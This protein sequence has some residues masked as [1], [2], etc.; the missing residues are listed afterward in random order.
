[1]KGTDGQYTY[2]KTFN[3]ER[4]VI[5][6]D[7]ISPIFFIIVLDQL[8]Q[9]YDKSGKGISVGHIK[10]LRV[11]GYADDAAM[12]EMAV[13]DMTKRLTEFA[14]AAAQE[15]DMTV[16][17]V[18]TYS[19]HLQQQEKV[20][21]ATDEEI[22]TKTA[23]YK[24]VC[25]FA[26]A[27]CKERF[28]TK[29]GMRIHSST[30]NFNYGLT[31]QKWEVEKIIAVFGRAERK[32]FLVRWAN[33][34]GEDS[35][36]KE[37]SLLQDGCAESIK[38]YWNNS[39]TNPALD[40]YPDPEGEPGTR[41]WMCGFK[42]SAKNKKLG[43]KTHI[44]RK[45]HAWTKHRANLTARKDIEKDKHEAAQ[46]KMPKVKW[47]NENV[48]NCWQFPYLGSLFQPDGDQMPDIRARCAMAKTRAGSLRHIWAAELP[49]DLKI[50][51]YIACCCSIMVWGSEAWV[52]DD[53]AK[54]CINGANAHML[55]HITG[56]TKREEATLGTTTFNI[57]AWI[58]ARRMRWV[59]HILRLP[60]ERLI[61]QTLK[62][63]FDNPQDGDILMDT[64]KKAGRS[65][66]GWQRRT[67]KK[68]GGSR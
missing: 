10:E 57:L 20:R 61:K 63:I 27:G 29:T 25:E 31:D 6:G 48:A 16:K 21:R 1:M 14:D 47:G 39:G 4:G 33:R 28:K 64:G 50:R 9:R 54:R 15:A 44:R 35:W 55:A 5:Q 43:L 3:I 58:R 45:K 7:I 40:Y 42:S 8:V 53:E 32:L 65:C 56:K 46:D 12:C 51:L 66:K 49:L 38:E 59:G 13:E 34:P 2:S 36:Q 41:C 52:L 62:V 67:T 26:K 19:Q 30:C 17:L 11:L 18:K 22:A 24:H 60:D 68:R 37:H 23:E